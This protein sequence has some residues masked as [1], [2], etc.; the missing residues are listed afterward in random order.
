MNSK[1]LISKHWGT[2]KKFFSQS[3]VVASSP[4]VFFWAGEHAALD[5]SIAICQ[6]I[7]LRVY[8]GLEPFRISRKGGEEIS[9]GDSLAYN[10]IQQKF[11][12]PL[13][14]PELD[15]KRPQIIGMVKQI[16]DL[17]KFKCRDFRIHI[18]SEYPS[19]AG[20]NWS[21]AFS[22]ALVIA[23]FELND[24]NS[25]IHFAEK[26]KEWN[27]KHSSEL[28][29]TGSLFDKCNRGA[30]RLESIFH[31]GPDC[32][33]GYGTFCSMISTAQPILYSNIAS[34]KDKDFDFID[35]R[36][37]LGARFCEL[38]G[39]KEDYDWPSILFG[40]I[41][42]GVQRE[43]EKSI[44]CS[45]A[46]K[47]PLEKA[48]QTV[49][50]LRTKLKTTADAARIEIDKLP[51]IKLCNEAMDGVSL[52][53]NYRKSLM[54]NV[55]DVFSS[56]CTLISDGLGV[57]ENN[58]Q[59]LARSLKGI[60]GNLHQLGQ[61]WFLGQMVS[62]NFYELAKH[63]GV[64]DKS[65]IKITGGGGGG[66]MF[67][68]TKRSGEHEGS[69]E[70]NISK[71]VMNIRK[72]RQSEAFLVWLSTTDLLEKEGVRIEKGQERST[73]ENDR[74]GKIPDGSVPISVFRPGQKA[75]MTY[76][77]YDGELEILRHESDFFV[78]LYQPSIL[79]RGQK[80]EYKLKELTNDVIL[81]LLTRIQTEPKTQLIT[82][83]E[84]KT[85]YSASEFKSKV[86]K[87]I[88]DHVR[89]A[90]GDG[91]FTFSVQSVKG[92][93]EYEIRFIQG[94]ITVVLCGQPQI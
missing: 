3:A 70:K 64:W 22:T 16:C 35:E 58:L 7:P 63:C 31:G 32:A 38:F 47:D 53:K 75:P 24:S 18:L 57:E 36:K 93:P 10:A 8:V 29:Q 54:T 78:D 11:I 72:K 45:R 68:V 34:E 15:A 40:L 81:K 62:L 30:W 37:Y 88:T 60:E 90:T 67:F 74:F 14:N 87:P 12:E 39:I 89:R 94:S 59:S 76:S 46:L 48:K 20:C 85:K 52:L 49:Q 82:L 21:G 19:S 55:T 51:V 86:T 61:D 79:S 91:R 77:V 28:V 33:S 50:Q 92:S 2:Y 56:L 26:V 27:N 9:F 80:I 43:T 65:A 44:K 17:E 23:M 73:E 1:D 42:S 69:M 6:H 71:M 25:K 84:E 41:Y 13:P 5:G 83:N 4:G 66:M